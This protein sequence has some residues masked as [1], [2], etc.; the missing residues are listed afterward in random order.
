MNWYNFV[1]VRD[2]PN[3]PRMATESGDGG[4]PATTTPTSQRPLI[5]P[6]PFSG[7]GMFSEWIEHFEAVAAINKWDQE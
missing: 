4:T 3:R 6:E 1:T 7:T 2:R 5:S